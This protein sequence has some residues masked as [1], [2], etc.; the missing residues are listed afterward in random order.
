[1]KLHRF[2]KKTTNELSFNERKELRRAAE[3]LIIMVFILL[4]MKRISA[5]AH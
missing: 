4:M 1:M 2:G 5:M 3:V